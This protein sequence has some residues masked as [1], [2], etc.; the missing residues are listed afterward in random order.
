MVTTTRN[1]LTASWTAD[2]QSFE[3]AVSRFTLD[4][5]LPNDCEVAFFEI[6]GDGHLHV[7]V[8]HK[9]QTT[10]ASGWA[11]PGQ[12]PAGFV[13]N[14]RFGDTGPNHVIRQIRNMVFAERIDDAR[15]DGSAR[16]ARRS[17]S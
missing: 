12:L 8:T 13:H 7:N 6:A 1:L 14:R 5:P 17:I 11:G 16:P 2:V 9:Y 3:S 10:A 15:K 4:R